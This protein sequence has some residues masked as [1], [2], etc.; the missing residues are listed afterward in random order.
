MHM[1]MPALEE[2][3]PCDLGSEHDKKGQQHAHYAVPLGAVRQDAG[4]AA[5]ILA[6]LAVLIGAQRVARGHAK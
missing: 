5:A 2:H 3:I 6:G 1:H 4:E